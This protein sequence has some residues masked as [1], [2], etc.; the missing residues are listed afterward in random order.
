MGHGESQFMHDA[1]GRLKTSLPARMLGEA[2]GKTILIDRN[3]AGYGW[4]VDDALTDD[5][6]SGVLGVD[7]PRNASHQDTI[8]ATLASQ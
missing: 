1:I 4:F 6:M 5:L 3:D 8:G 7:V 2:I